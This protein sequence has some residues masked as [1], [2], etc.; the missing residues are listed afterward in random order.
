MSTIAMSSVKELD[1]DPHRFMASSFGR[2]R[3]IVAAGD[4]TLQDCV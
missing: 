1:K 4:S 3:W 2:E